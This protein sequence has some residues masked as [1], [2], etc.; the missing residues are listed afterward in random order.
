MTRGR[1]AAQL[2]IAATF[3]VQIPGEFHESQ[4]NVVPVPAG[5]DRGLDDFTD[6]RP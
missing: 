3:L 6:E 1:R 2:Q 5:S 4:E